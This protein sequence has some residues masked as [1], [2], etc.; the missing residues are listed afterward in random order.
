MT[1]TSVPRSACIPACLALPE[2]EAISSQAFPSRGA[3]PLDPKHLHEHL[4]LIR[5]IKLGQYNALPLAQHQCAP[6]DRH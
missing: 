1:S 6:I 3:H 5:A 4:A 2:K